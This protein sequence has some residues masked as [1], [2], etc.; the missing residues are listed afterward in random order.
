MSIFA[1]AITRGSSN[2]AFRHICATAA[3]P[4]NC[5]IEVLLPEGGCRL[6]LSCSGWSA[7]LGVDADGGSPDG[8]LTKEGGGRMA[9][10]WCPYR[11]FAAMAGAVLDL[12]CEV[13]TSCDR[14]TRYSA[15][16]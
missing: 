13:D 1:L 9:A 3:A 7:V 12:I 6:W 5:S 14:F 15:Q 4:G 2:L 10:R 16:T 11:L 8:D